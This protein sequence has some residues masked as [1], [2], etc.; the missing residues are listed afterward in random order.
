MSDLI[1]DRIF[2]NA[3][4]DVY[5][6]MGDLLFYDV[7]PHLEEDTK[8]Y[9]GSG[10]VYYWQQVDVSFE[11]Y[12]QTQILWDLLKEGLN[13]GVSIID[14][15][16]VNYVYDEFKFEELFFETFNFTFSLVYDIMTD[17]AESVVL[18]HLDLDGITTQYMR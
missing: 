5:D 9:I 18:P 2:A 17:T 1:L 6:S 13:D 3:P 15:D 12:V 14:D 10:S 4:Y 11:K 7:Y 8:Q 16:Y